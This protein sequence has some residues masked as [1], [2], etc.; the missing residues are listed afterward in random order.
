M[1]SQ[2]IREKFL[3]YFEKKGHTRVPSSSLVP[4][5]DPTLLFTNAGMVQFKDVFLGNKKLPYKRAVTAQKCVRAGGKH[6]D[7]DSVG[8]TARHHT[9]FEMLGN[10]SFGDY[11]KRDAISFAWEFLT[12]E[13][14][15]PKEKLWVTIYKDDDEAFD[16]WQ[17][18]TGIPAERIIR[19]GEK[20]NF[21]S[22]GDTG[23]CGPCSEI[24][25][26]RGEEER[27]EAP[28]CG[29]GKCDCDRW[30]EIWNLVF[31]Q[32]NRDENG[33]L[34]P[35]PKPSIDTGM[36]LERISTVL[37]GV[38]SN[39]D[40]DLLRPLIIFTEKLTGKKYYEDDRGF[41][42]RVIADHIRACSFLISDGV[43]PSNE[44]RG[45]VLRRILRRAVRFGKVLGMDE[46]FLFK[47]VPEVVSIMGEAYPEIIK[48]NEFIQ[49]VIKAEEERFLETL[50]EGIKIVQD[51]IKRIKST[52]KNTISGQE[53]FVLY[54]TYGFPLDLT[55]DIAEENGLTVD[56]E[57]FEKEME[58]QRVRAKK[59]REEAFKGDIMDV[60]MEELKHLPATEFLGYSQ[61]QA[62]GRVIALYSEETSINSATINDY[63]RVILDRTPFYAESGG[64]LGDKG[65]LKSDEFEIEVEDTQKTADGKIVHIGTVK[66]GKV[67]VNDEVEA[68]V[69]G[70]RRK[71]IARNH[72][73]THLLH[74][75]LRELL[76]EHVKQSG[77]LVDSERLR[78]DFSHFTSLSS[79][80]LKQIEKRVNTMIFE[81]L[82]VVVKET[83]VQDAIKQGAIALFGEKYGEKV[84]MIEI[85]EY[86]KELC[87]GT[88]VRRTGEI[89]MFKI[90]SE[91]SIG[92]GL[93]RIEAITGWC[94]LNYLTKLEEKIN[95]ISSILKSKPEEIKEKIEQL[96]QRTKEQQKQIEALQDRL[97]SSKLTDLM[98]NGYSEEV[99]GHS[100][101]S[102]RVEAS[103]MDAL[104]KISDM[105]KQKI[106]SG[107]IILGAKTGEKLS[108]VTVVTKDL[109]EKGINAA[110]IIKLVSKE[111][112]G[113][114]GGRP[115]MAQAG[116][117]SPEK[118]DT[119]LKK[120]IEIAKIE[121]SKL[122]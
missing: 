20:D 25:I 29:I 7:L 49:K 22:M 85:G 46:P 77:S 15:I 57:G 9:F 45:Y 101:L 41:P 32:Y 100:V 81:D 58:R 103:N 71:A 33:N 42:F 75:A 80:E 48:M 99:N 84:R 78:F 112:D 67:N 31:M 38:Y 50:N 24:F 30:R 23:P 120:G 114:G 16:L 54:D 18:I 51:M 3:R 86:S 94:V 5:D 40:T 4:Q 2:E 102:I 13:L 65:V 10:F 52:G 37:Q 117:K 122:V 64:Q 53:A 21:W 83:T 19:L 121:L 82:E 105:L 76:G 68:V 97:V 55:E 12:E 119:A 107:I 116:G 17:E 26:D 47:I 104:R 87:G 106:D 108:F 8:R 63:I 28:E 89:G 1:K 111:A 88:H 62:I 98:N 74:K 95:D 115:D 69:D 39:Y 36:G 43:M 113:S 56:K 73:A 96:I 60:I 92:S 79:N 118:L 34:T 59:A 66:K 93:R 110:D 44:G 109:V 72:S 35:L 70:I 61:T 90:I 91:G 6:N 11:F 14:G 27:C